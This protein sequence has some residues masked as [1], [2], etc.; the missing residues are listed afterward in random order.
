MAT[1]V[2]PQLPP[3]LPLPSVSMHAVLPPPPLPL[4][5]ESPPVAW[6]ASLLRC[7]GVSCAPPSRLDELE[8]RRILM[9]HCRLSSQLVGGSSHPP[10]RPE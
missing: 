5:A 7:A 10:G 9:R 2:G 1:T 4:P 3:L 6:P 8:Q